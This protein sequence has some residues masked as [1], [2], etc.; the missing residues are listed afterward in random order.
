M[1]AHST[2]AWFYGGIAATAVVLGYLVGASNSPVAG[3]A[4]TAI[5]GLGVA[6]VGLLKER[7][8]PAEPGPAATLSSNALRPAGIMLT[9]FSL[10]YLAAILGSSVLRARLSQPAKVPVPWSA[11]AIPSTPQSAL[12]WLVVQRRLMAY[13]YTPEQVR[14]LYEMLHGVN[15]APLGLLG[16]VPEPGPSMKQGIPA[17][18]VAKKPTYSVHRPFSCRFPSE[19]EWFAADCR[20]SGRIRFVAA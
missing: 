7:S 1:R 9:I 3:S 8:S 2:H 15:N 12:E 5:F 4:I 20:C 16:S 11:N 18:T 19:S 10:T 6:A 14:K 17:G 13:G